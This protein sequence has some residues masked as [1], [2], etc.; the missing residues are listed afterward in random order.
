MN[1]LIFILIIF[2]LTISLSAQT[3]TKNPLVFK[4]TKN[5]W[6]GMIRSN[7]IFYFY[8]SGR[9]DC[10]SESTLPRGL[11]NRPRDGL[12]RS[13]K[14]KCNQISQTKM[15]ELIEIAEQADFQSTKESYD[16]FAMGVD[17]GRSL[18]IT[19]FRQSGQKKIELAHY[20]R[21]REKE[22]IPSVLK[23]FLQKIGE[24]D[25]TLKVETEQ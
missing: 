20:S 4:I 12:A 5:Q 19:H 25:E 15:K 2:A 8:Q 13:K 9:I 23:I 11:P 16:Y 24:I 22:Q 14:S 1:K 3:K 7:S 21:F 6:G 10:Q 17:Y 18:S